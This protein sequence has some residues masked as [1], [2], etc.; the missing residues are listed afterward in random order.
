MEFIIIVDESFENEYSKI[1]LEDFA[2]KIELLKQE[3]NC[4]V[5]NIN[6]AANRAEDYL[7]NIYRET[8][9]YDN[10][11]YIPNNMPMFNIDETVKLTKI[12][13]ENI[14]Y[15]TYGENYPEGIIP[16][17][18]RRNAFEKLFNCI[19]TK[20]INITENAIKDIV[21]IDPNFF[22]IEIL[23]SEY[24]MRYYRIS[25]FA[26]SKRNALLISKLIKLLLYKPIKL[27]KK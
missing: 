6:Y 26:N 22:E 11:I 2:K 23:V 21:F 5:K 27:L 25:L 15:F 1:F 12:H 4:D 7:N 16:F 13:N 8:E 9:N 3:L 17:I 14:S 20:N 10:I 24:D 18:I 19:K